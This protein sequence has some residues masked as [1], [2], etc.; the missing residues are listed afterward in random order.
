MKI[1]FF[2]MLIITVIFINTKVIA[3]DLTTQMIEE[4]A[5]T[6][7]IT[8]FVSE[9]EEYSGDFFEDISISDLISS[10]ISGDIDNSTILKKV[11]NGF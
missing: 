1:K 7:G 11:L 9:A 6:F 5:E 10:A 3:T 8:D 2:Y 4:Q